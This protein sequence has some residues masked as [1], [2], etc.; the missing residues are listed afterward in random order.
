MGLI[1]LSL[2][3][4]SLWPPWSAACQASVLHY[5]PEFA[6]THVHWVVD[7]IQSSRPLSSPSPPAFYLSQHQGLF[8]ESTLYIRWAKYWSF[9][10]S[11]SP[12]NG[13]SRLISFRTDWFNLLAV[14]GTPKGLLQHHSSNTSVLHCSAF[15]TVQLSH[16]YMT[17]GK[18][19]ALTK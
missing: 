4:V 15:F 12:C 3:H 18:T 10:F 17:T 11:I 9:N 7:A 5:L 6:Q 16:L 14:Q 19:V 13:Y 1:V 8:H 2:N